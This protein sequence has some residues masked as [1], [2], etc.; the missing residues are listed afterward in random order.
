MSSTIDEIKD[1]M[2]RN[3]TRVTVDGQTWVCHDADS[4]EGLLASSRQKIADLY[5]ERDRA[6]A[7]LTQ[8]LRLGL[9]EAERITTE[10]ANDERYTKGERHGARMA[11][12][13]IRARLAQLERG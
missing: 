4:P 9:D 11:G 5:I 12:A 7:A 13:L 1:A 3:A 8:A 2:Y 6:L 10:V